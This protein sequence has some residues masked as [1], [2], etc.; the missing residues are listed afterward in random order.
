MHF[1]L[2]SW[3]FTF[4][5]LE[6][7]FI[8]R[9][10]IWDLLRP[11][12]FSITPIHAHAFCEHTIII[13]LTS[14]I[15]MYPVTQEWKRS[16]YFTLFDILCYHVT[17]LNLSKWRSHLEQHVLMFNCIVSTVVI[18][19]KSARRTLEY[20]DF[21]IILISRKILDFLPNLYYISFRFKHIH[22]GI[23][24]KIYVLMLSAMH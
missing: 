20:I 1:L 13:I 16:S 22:S 21:F 8:T 9:P 24:R 18:V 2:F 10:F 5:N 3:I 4:W 17:L 11:L 14:I 12:H 15:P 19:L 6:G 7:I 23:F